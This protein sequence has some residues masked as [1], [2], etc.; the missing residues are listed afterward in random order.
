[1]AARIS[2]SARSEKAS[3][4]AATVAS[5]YSSSSASRRRSPRSSALSWPL[6]SPQF[7]CGTRELAARISTMSWFI[8]PGAEE[9]HRREAHAFLK[10]FGRLRIVAARHIAADVEPVPDRGEPAEQLAV[11]EDRA[12]EPEIVEMRAAVIGI[13]EQEGVAG[14]QPAV[15]RDL[16]DHRLHRERHGA[17]EDRQPVRAL[18]QRRAGRR[19]DRARGRRRA[20]RR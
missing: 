2:A 18:H 1:M 16:V 14:C 8:T 5:P 11:A 6:R 12:H 20:P 7:D 17:D 15:A 3:K 10:A 19:R 4:A 13:V 9:F